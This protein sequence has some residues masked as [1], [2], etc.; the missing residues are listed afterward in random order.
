MNPTLEDIES[1]INGYDF[2]K[3]K[4]RVFTYI[5]FVKMFGFNNDVNVF[6]NQ[7][8]TYVYKWANIKKEHITISDDD[9]VIG[10]MVEILKSITL[11]Y[12]SYEEQDFIA[13]IDLNNKQH[14]KALSALYSRKIRQITEFYR[15]KRNES[16]MIVHKNS[17]KG[18]I[19][20]IE[21]IIYEK[22][23]D[24]LFSD[25]NTIVSFSDIRRDLMISVE[26]YVDIYSEYFDIP[27]QKDFTDKTREEMLSANINDVDYRTYLEIELVISEILFSGNVYLEEIPLVAQLGVDL[28]QSCVGDMLALKNTLLANTTINQVPL[29]EQVALKRKL[30]EKYLGCDL[31]YMYVD[32]QGNIKMDILCKASNPSGNLLNCGTA[33]TATIESNQL[34]LLSH[35]GLFFKPD[36][37]SILKVNAKKFTWEIDTSLLQNDTMYVFPDPNRYG[38]IGNNKSSSYPLIM[39][40]KLDWDVKNISSGEAVNDPLMLLGD[41]GWKSYYS[42][43][44]DDFKVFDNTD[45]E[46]AFTYLADKGQLTDYQTDAWGNQFGLFKLA[47][48]ESETLSLQDILNMNTD[49]VVLNGGYFED[50]KYKGKEV[51]DDEKEKYTWVLDFEEDNAIKF[52]YKEQKIINENYLWSG[53]TVNNEKMFYDK[54]NHINCG[55]FGS[56]KNYKYTDNFQVVGKGTETILLTYQKPFYSIF[57]SLGKLYIRTSSSIYNKPQLF[58]E[59]FPWA[60]YTIQD[61]ELLS[62]QVIH[63]HIIIET[64]DSYVFIPYTYD[65][66]NILNVLDNTPIIQLDKGG[67]GS[68]LIYVAE[69]KCFYIMFLNHQENMLLPQCYK[70]NPKEYTLKEV[71]NIADSPN[72]DLKLDNFTSDGKFSFDFSHNSSLRI[73]TLTVLYYDNLGS[74]CLYNYKFKMDNNDIFNQTLDGKCYMVNDVNITSETL[75]EGGFY[76]NDRKLLRMTPNMQYVNVIDGFLIREREK[77]WQIIIDDDNILNI[78]V[79]KDILGNV[80]G[81][82]IKIDE[83]NNRKIEVIIRGKNGNINPSV[84]I[85]NLR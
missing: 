7:Y 39:E 54:A 36:K 5:E 62:I 64:N 19:K 84:I 26:N 45:F 85:N 43:Q 70:F 21:E 42:K 56:H 63:E 3:D 35:I 29:T 57:D 48:G 15:K 68:K 59:V 33:D 44:D 61:K 79:K 52:D 60:A 38:D 8:K 28:S 18:S 53:I 50:P 17:L 81:K 27:R 65:G 14:L 67:L 75:E 41:Q 40:Y 6:I 66:N 46:Y 10:K 31:Y 25:R 16:V 74:P 2:A 37:I 13:N 22:V 49:A 82:G 71:I 73:Y 78:E 11:D 47:E 83:M 20:S 80:Y 4:N 51:W 55:T 69:D 77:D 23:F 72:D 12:S 9:F 58:E 32:L 1:I 24:Y 30:Y 34:E 76:S